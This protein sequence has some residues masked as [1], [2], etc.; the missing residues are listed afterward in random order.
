MQILHPFLKEGGQY[1]VF[2]HEKRGFCHDDEFHLS[3]IF[4]VSV[5]KVR[6]NNEIMKK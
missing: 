6:K 3:D 4:F 1:L 2:F 5:A